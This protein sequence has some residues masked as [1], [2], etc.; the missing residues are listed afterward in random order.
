[1][2][3]WLILVV[4]IVGCTA[5]CLN[6]AERDNCL[7]GLAIEQF[8]PRICFKITR[9]TLKDA[10]YHDTAI[11]KDSA[12]MCNKIESADIRDNCY[13]A[14]GQK[15]DL[16]ANSFNQKE[17]YNNAPNKEELGKKLMKKCSRLEEVKQTECYMELAYNLNYLPAC[18]MRSNEYDIEYCIVELNQELMDKSLC[19]TINDNDLKQKCL[20]T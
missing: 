5:P 8:S 19:E 11:L 10:C 2:Y 17:C 12:I 18:E 16:V 4:L 15:C 3:R 9:I 7:A 14:L 1:M 20:T 6:N 13:I